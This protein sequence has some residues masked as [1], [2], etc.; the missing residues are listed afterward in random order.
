MGR[1]RVT[2]KDIKAMTEVGKAKAEK[3]K[4]EG[5]ES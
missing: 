4:V 1:V 2:Q 3:V 5:K